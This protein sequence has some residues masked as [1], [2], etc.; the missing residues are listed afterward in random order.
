MKVLP[1]GD[2]NDFFQKHNKEDFDQLEEIGFLDL[3][4][5][6]IPSDTAKDKL[7]EL[8]GPFLKKLSS[9][10]PAK[11]RAV[12]IGAGKKFDWSSKE[13]DT[14]VQ[15][16]NKFAKELRFI[17]Q[18]QLVEKKVE[19]KEVF[20][21][22]VVKEAEEILMSSTLLY[23][24]LKMVHKCGI[25]GEE[26]NL[27]THYLSLSSRLLES[28]I[29]VTVKGDSSAGKSFVL[30]KVLKLF[31]KSAYIDITDATAQSFYYTP[32]DHFKHKIIV[33]FEKHGGEKTDYAIR[34]LQSEGKLKIQTTVKNP[35]TNEFETMEVEREGPTGFITTTTDSMIHAENETR[36]IS[37]FPDQSQK[38]TNDIYEVIDAKYLGI[39]KPSDD[40]LKPWQCSQTL[41]EQ[42]P[43]CIPFVKSLSKH[44]PSHILRTRR[45][46]SHF[47]AFIEVSAFFHQK[48]RARESIDGINYIR[49]TLADYEIARIVVEDSLSKSIYEL[50]PKTIELILVARKLSVDKKDDEE[51]ELFTITELAK[52]ISWDRDTVA[53]WMEPGSKKSYFTIV[54][55]SKGSKGAKYKVEEKDL[56]GA[57]FLP[58]VSILAQENPKEIIEGIYNPITGALIDISQSDCTDAPMSLR[59]QQNTSYGQENTPLKSIG[60]SVENF[61]DFVNDLRSIPKKDKD[62]IDDINKDF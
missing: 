1:S 5:K 52:K 40:I 12:L 44:F 36:N 9:E 61:D 20:S 13:I 23:E 31:P 30:G 7:P 53:K 47:L 60:A 4:L 58:K 28:P 43:V 3:L 54:H 41:F 26:K 34:S 22:K 46:Y 29:S 27:L 2:L 59:E 62:G 17:E 16:V 37:I 11:I 42:L 25:V 38:Q 48:Q 8:L 57:S 21:P 55:E 14:Y 39:K 6:E 51:K 33:I 24:A 56:P 49:A 32:E 19:E 35:D 15:T 45:D 10:N 50:P 18:N